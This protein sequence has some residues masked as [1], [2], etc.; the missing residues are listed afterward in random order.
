MKL[1]ISDKTA[2]RYNA[3]MDKFLKAQRRFTQKFG[4]TWDPWTQPITVKWNK[5]ERKAWNLIAGQVTDFVKRNGTI[6]PT[7]YM[8]DYLVK[9]T[10]SA[11]AVASMTKGVGVYRAAMLGAL[12][13]LLRGL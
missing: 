11:V 9:N 7:D 2:K 8:S 10:A 4:R 3:A 13:E 6:S 12:Y 5:A 1:N